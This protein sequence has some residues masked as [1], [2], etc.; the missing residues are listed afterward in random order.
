MKIFG[1][2]ERG[3]WRDRSSLANT[4]RLD[5]EHIQRSSPHQKG[6]WVHR[7]GALSGM[8]YESDI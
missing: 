4:L 5:P 6:R 1:E 3:R 2:G 7:G 8:R